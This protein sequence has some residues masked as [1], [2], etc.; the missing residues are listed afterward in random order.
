MSEARLYELAARF[1]AIAD[2]L[3]EL[4]RMPLSLPEG[5]SASGA[6]MHLAVAI[7]EHPEFTATELAAELGVT[8]G[9]ISQLVKKLE[10]RDIIVRGEKA[11]DGKSRALKLTSAGKKLAVLHGELHGVNRDLFASLTSKYDEERLNAMDDFLSD[12]ESLIGETRARIER[13]EVSIARK[14]RGSAG[15]GK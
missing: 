4:E 8:K 12:I 14:R 1:S 6:E 5:G 10:E 13:R 11:A 2:D 7:A 3:G 15:D 9:A